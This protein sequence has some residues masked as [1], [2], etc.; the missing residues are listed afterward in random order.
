MKLLVIYYCILVEESKTRFFFFFF[1]CLRKKKREQ[2]VTSLYKKL[3][4]Y[5]FQVEE[6][7]GIMACC[8]MD[9]H[10]SILS[11]MFLTQKSKGGSNSLTV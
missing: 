5:S 6:E 1:F 7:E 11:E 8:F 3:N 10:T 2:G 4:K 9:V